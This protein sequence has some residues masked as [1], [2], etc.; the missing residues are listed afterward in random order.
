[1]IHFPDPVFQSSRFILY[2][3]ETERKLQDDSNPATGHCN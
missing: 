2:I 1:M 3:H